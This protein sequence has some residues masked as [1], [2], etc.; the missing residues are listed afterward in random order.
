MPPL[1]V[2]LLLPL[3]VYDPS[4]YYGSHFALNLPPTTLIVAISVT[5]IM[6][7]DEK[8]YKESVMGRPQP[9]IIAH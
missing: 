6:A 9:P 4:F 8:T 3:L 7:M 5:L 1:G 2:S